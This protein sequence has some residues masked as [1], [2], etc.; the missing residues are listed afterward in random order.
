MMAEPSVS[1]ITAWPFRSISPKE[2]AELTDADQ[3]GIEQVAMGALAKL[4]FFLTDRGTGKIR[5]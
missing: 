3:L 1:A 2:Y 4:R 5:T